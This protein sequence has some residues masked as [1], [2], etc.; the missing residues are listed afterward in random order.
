MKVLP[1]V[2]WV[3]RHKQ[4]LAGLTF[5]HQLRRAVVK[6]AKHASLSECQQFLARLCILTL[7][8]KGKGQ[9]S[10]VALCVHFCDGKLNSGRCVQFEV[11]DHGLEVLSGRLRQS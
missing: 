2:V 10:R 5:A 3:D 9:V 11:G 1:N 8:P 6:A 4:A 7:E